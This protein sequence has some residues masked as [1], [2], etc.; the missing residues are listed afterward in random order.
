MRSRKPGDGPSE[1]TRAKSRFRVTFLAE[2]GGHHVQT[3]VSGHD[4]GYGE[5]A[6]M[7]AESALCLAHDELPS[8]AGQVTTATAMGGALT[9][10]LEAAGITF[11]V[12]EACLLLGLFIPQLL[13]TSPTARWAH[14]FLYL[15][16]SAGMLIV[17]PSVRRGVRALL[18][19]AT[20]FHVAR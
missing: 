6:K 17:S 11:S 1:E 15:A 13:L 18:P 3:T 19:L 12:L 14:A 8:T 2:A 9:E 5:T 10:R 16:L 20:F 4:P 7:L